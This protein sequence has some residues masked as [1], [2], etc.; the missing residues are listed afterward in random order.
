MK[1][2]LDITQA[3][4]N[5][6]AVANMGWAECLLAIWLADSSDLWP[7]TLGQEQACVMWK[8]MQALGRATSMIKP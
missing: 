5:H 2:P 6:E 8:W 7:L 1:H 4:F 3:F